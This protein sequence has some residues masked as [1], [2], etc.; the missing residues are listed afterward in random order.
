MRDACILFFRELDSYLEGLVTLAGP[1]AQVFIV[2][3]HGFT[4]TT[5]VVRINTFL[6]ERGYLA[7]REQDDSELGRKRDASNFANVDWDKTLAYCRTPSSNGICIRVAKE[8]GEPGIRPEEYERFRDR[9]IADLRD[10]RD[11]QT[12]EAIIRDILPR[13]EYFRGKKMHEAPD[14]TLVLR[15]YGFVS[16]RNLS[17]PLYKRPAPA[18]THHPDGIFIAGGSGIRAG[19]QLE[20]L[21]IADV[22]PTVLYSLGLSVPEDLEGCVPADLFT[23]D[24]L[25]DNPI[26]IGGP[27]QPV[28]DGEVTNE[29][30]EEADKERL[31]AQLQMLGYM[32]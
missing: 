17:P 6:E 16:I 22:A 26:R 20:R 15:D 23:S 31:M 8:P 11:P 9:L 19:Q 7:W 27:T 32:E 18:G 29:E 25:A 30:M 14:L 2:S 24:Y 10:L 3:D 21:N 5:E 1:Q 12:G 4:T 13:E 28:L